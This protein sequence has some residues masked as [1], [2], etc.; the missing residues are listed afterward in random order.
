MGDLEQSALPRGNLEL[1]ELGVD[2]GVIWERVTWGTVTC[3]SAAWE[4][5]TW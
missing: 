4:S 1:D 2:L 3:D 5:A